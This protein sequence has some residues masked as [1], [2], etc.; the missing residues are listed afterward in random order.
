MEITKK[1]LTVEFCLPV[2][3]EEGI[4]ENSIKK[5]MYFCE[6]K[7]FP[8]DWRIVVVSNGSTDSSVEIARCLVGP[9]CVLENIAEAGRGRALRNYWHRS[10]ADLLVYMDVDLAVS[11][12]DIS[13][14]LNPLLFGEADL[15]IGSRLLPTSKISR[16]LIREASSRGYSLVSRLILNHPYKDLQCGFKAIRKTAFEAIFPFLEENK[17]FFDTELIIFAHRKNFRIKEIPVDW[18]ENRYDLR[19]SKVKIFRDTMVFIKNLIR[20]KFRLE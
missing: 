17:W 20:L 5:L 2:F 12:D 14:L 16:S 13:D 15:V 3:N 19:R 9:K 6:K 1:D 8:Y 11:L 7:Q 18:S 10:N 4:L